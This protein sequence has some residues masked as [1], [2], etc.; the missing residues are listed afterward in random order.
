MKDADEDTNKRKDT[1]CSW[2]KRI[3]TVRMSTLPK[4]IHRLHVIPI[5][6][7]ISFFT[8]IENTTLKFV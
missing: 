5:Q 3:N 2:V 8:E 4:A 6:I 7:P 1:L